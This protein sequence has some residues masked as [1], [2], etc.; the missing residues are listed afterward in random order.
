M[1]SPSVYHDILITHNNSPSIYY[2]KPVVHQSFPL[3]I[4]FPDAAHHEPRST[5]GSST[6]PVPTSCPSHQSSQ[7]ATASTQTVKPPRRH[8]GSPVFS[9]AVVIFQNPKQYQVI[10]R[11][12]YEVTLCFIEIDQSRQPISTKMTTHWTTR[13]SRCATGRPSSTRPSVP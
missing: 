12:H 3:T 4:S 8:G 5:P 10:I 13:T 6:A 9:C 7:P 11:S 1:T 2:D